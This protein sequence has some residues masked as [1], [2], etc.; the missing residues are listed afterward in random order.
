MRLD[1]KRILIVRRDAYP[2]ETH[3]LR[4]VTA[5]LEDGFEV[6]LVC[7]KEPGQPYVERAGLLRI[8]RVPLEHRRGNLWRTFAEYWLFFAVLAFLVPIRF[9]ASKPRFVEID[10]MPNFL[11]FS[12]LLPRALGATVVLYM[13]ELIPETYC[14]K[15]K[16][17]MHHPIVRAIVL[18][19]RLSAMFASRIIVY[20]E[21]MADALATRGIDPRKMHVVYNVPL[22]DRYSLEVA[23]EPKEPGKVYFIHHGL[24]A[25]HYG[26]QYLLQAL[27]IV[28]DRLRPCPPIQLDI[29]GKGE[30]IS[31]LKA[32][33][34]R[35]KFHTVEVVFWG[36]VPD[37]KLVAL[38][39][40]ADAGV[41]P[42]VSDILSPNKL[43]D[44]AYFAKP[45][46]CSR[47]DA[48]TYHF[49]DDA[50]LYFAK[51]DA[52]DIAEKLETFILKKDDLSRRLSARI[53]KIYETMSW[54]S[55][56]AR[57]L[58]MYASERKA[59]HE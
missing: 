47:V 40:R 5:L 25:E 15:L 7:L 10:T 52:D 37:E 44:L 3:V 4:N 21:L 24:V 49:P 8:Y 43:F 34:E 19:E 57:Y 12:A 31:A 1:P 59:L 36:F 2:R 56:K 13:F 30:Y 54:R 18:E 28:E 53:A 29:V 46:L 9:L 14:E 41:L 27:K 16:V 38:L 32:L 35:L 17:G 39:K 6:E 42:L 33:T 26:L 45:V 50:I 22:E 58:S 11:V 55:Q 23:A 51:G 48:I 20:H